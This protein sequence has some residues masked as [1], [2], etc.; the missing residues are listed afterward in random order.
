ME[1][2][3]EALIA[4]VNTMLGIVMKLLNKKTE[5]KDQQMLLDQTDDKEE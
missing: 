1:D 2:D 4:G 3:K 5:K